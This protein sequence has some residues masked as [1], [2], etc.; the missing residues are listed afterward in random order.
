MVFPQPFD[1]RAAGA[2][3]KHVVSHVRLPRLL[4]KLQGGGPAALTR[5]GSDTR[6]QA[7][8]ILGSAG[9]HDEKL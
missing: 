6:G 3:Q 4:R 9:K 2:G 5:Q 7:E 1:H 8:T